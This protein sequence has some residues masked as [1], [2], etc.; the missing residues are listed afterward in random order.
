MKIG[1]DT[2]VLS[3]LIKSNE[4]DSKSKI[5]QFLYDNK[6]TL[7]I[8][9]SHI[10]LAEVMVGFSQDEV[11]KMYTLLEEIGNITPLAFDQKSAIQNSTLVKKL[12]LQGYGDKDRQCVKSDYL[13]CSNYMAYGCD[14]FMAAD[15]DLIQKL[16][17]H[18]SM[19]FIN[20]HTLP[21]S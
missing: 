9:I 7:E 3:S 4:Q 8:V 1:L 13:I 2:N 19:Q 10:V 16:Q 20:P 5:L 6:N 17:P 11:D 14:C 12:G 21:N 15:K 18:T